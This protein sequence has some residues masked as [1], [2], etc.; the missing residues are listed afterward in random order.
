MI[1]KG[2][3]G[4]ILEGENTVLMLQVAV[5]IEK[6]YGTVKKTGE[7]EKVLDNLKYFADVDKFDGLCQKK[8]RNAGAAKFR[9]VDFYLNA[10]GQ[11]VISLVKKTLSQRVVLVKT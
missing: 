9:D 11:T 7:T 5:E 2:F 1:D 6:T 8:F 4:V 10:F 3:A